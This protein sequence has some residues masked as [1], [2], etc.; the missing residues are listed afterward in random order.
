MWVL[1]WGRGRRGSSPQARGKRRHYPDASCTHRLIPAGAGKT[2]KRAR[3]YQPLQAHPRRRGENT[4]FDPGLT[5]DAG[6]S[7]QARGKR[8]S[9]RAT[10]GSSGLIPAGAG[11]TPHTAHHHAPTEAHPRRRG[12]NNSARMASTPASGSSPQARGKRTVVAADPM[13]PRLIPAGAGRTMPSTS[14]RGRSWAHPRRRGENANLGVFDTGGMGSSPQAR[15]KH[16][17]T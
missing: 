6:S 17:R 7:P 3:V 15:G 1:T 12:E 11:K 16:L 13:A 4:N 2:I 8:R 10:C 9:L 14:T 5:H